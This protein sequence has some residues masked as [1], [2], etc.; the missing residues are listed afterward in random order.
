M[1][2]IILLT[3][4]DA[5]ASDTDSL[6]LMRGFPTD[7][8]GIEQG[9]SACYAGSID[10]QLIMAGGCNFPVNTL[11]PDSKKVYYSGIYAARTDEVISSVG[12]RLAVCQSHWL[13]VSPLRAI[14]V[15]LLSVE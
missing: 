5:N 8:V 2:T 14:T 6:M 15:W 9:V 3:G 7:E 4:L 13:M 1:T 11:A 10:N 12:S